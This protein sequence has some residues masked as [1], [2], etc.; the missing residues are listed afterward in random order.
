MKLNMS[1]FLEK[2]F[3]FICC[4]GC[5]NASQ[6]MSQLVQ[7]FKSAR[8]EPASKKLSFHLTYHKGRTRKLSSV[9]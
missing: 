2:K 5:S 3:R 7:A 6:K 1:A 8:S 4:R 9:W